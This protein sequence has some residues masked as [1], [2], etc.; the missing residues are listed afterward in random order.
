MPSR[1][2]EFLWTSMRNLIDFHARYLRRKEP[3]E[4]GNGTAKILGEY[5][6]RNS[7]FIGWWARVFD[8]YINVS[9]ALITRVNA[10]SPN[11]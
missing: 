3:V 1:E 6:D 8:P 5:A 9:R 2:R 4:L 11:G 7:Y 10:T